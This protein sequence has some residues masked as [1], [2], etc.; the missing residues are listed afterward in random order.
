[1]PV[2]TAP[3]YKGMARLSGLEITGMEDPPKV[4]NP[5]LTGLNAYY[6]KPATINN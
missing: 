3:N 6:A 5:R 1:M 2:L 4:N